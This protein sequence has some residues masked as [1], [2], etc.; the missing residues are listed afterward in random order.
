MTDPT[1]HELR[2]FTEEEIATVK[3]AADGPGTSPLTLHKA[4]PRNLPAERRRSKRIKRER[5]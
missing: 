3:A 5:E 2:M 1:Q 4:R